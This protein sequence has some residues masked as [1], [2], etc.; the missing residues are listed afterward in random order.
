M[1]QLEQPSLKVSR[2]LIAAGL[3][4]VVGLLGSVG[5]VL[6]C[7]VFGS[8]TAFDPRISFLAGAVFLGCAGWATYA[9]PGSWRFVRSLLFIFLVS[10]SCWFLVFGVVKVMDEELSDHLRACYKGDPFLRPDQALV[11]FS[12]PI[13]AAQLL[14][15]LRLRWASKGLFAR[16]NEREQSRKD[17]SLTCLPTDLH[18]GRIENLSEPE[19]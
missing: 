14:V 4:A 15:V 19:R 13:G 18:A 7:L 17:V 8:G 1:G 6:L 16:S 10:L 9:P 11:L 5:L 3:L 2:G 12:P